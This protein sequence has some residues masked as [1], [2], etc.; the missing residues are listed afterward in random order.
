MGFSQEEAEKI[1]QIIKEKRSQSSS[2]DRVDEMIKYGPRVNRMGGKI[3]YIAKLAKGGVSGGS[4]KSTEKGKQDVVTKRAKNSGNAASLSE[5]G[6]DNWNSADTADLVALGAD[7]AA[8]G[9]IFADPTN[10]AGAGAGVAASLSRFY[11]DRTRH[12]LNPDAGKGAGWNLALN[13][14]MDA[15]SLIPVVGDATQ[16]ARTAN[17]IRKSLPT[18][19]KLV[20][21]AGMGDAAATAAI[22]IANGD[23]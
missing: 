11:A 23:K 8:A 19:L 6:T 12:Q 22:K 1:R 18:I 10:I 14:G 21:V 5:I 20:S 17:T 15:V 7:L 4:T 2:R 16:A 3:D 9:V 13:L